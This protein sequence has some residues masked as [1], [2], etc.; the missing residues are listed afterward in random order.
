MR[1][2]LRVVSSSPGRV[3]EKRALHSDPLQARAGALR[4][5][6]HGGFPTV[7]KPRSPWSESAPEMK[8]ARRRKRA[9]SPA[10]RV[11]P[12]GNWQPSGGDWL[13]GGSVVTGSGAGE[14]TLL[15]PLRVI[16]PCSPYGGFVGVFSHQSPTPVDSLTKA[17]RSRSDP[18]PGP[19]PVPLYVSGY[20]SLRRR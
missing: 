17:S 16:G 13:S 3:L 11:V 15:H 9:G 6:V 8:E 10:P 20:R 12:K 4:T 19:R 14:R 2:H 5:L 7:D 1:K 18:D